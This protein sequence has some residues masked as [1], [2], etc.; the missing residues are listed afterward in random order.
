M[1]YFRSYRSISF[2][3]LILVLSFI[4]TQAQ[5]TTNVITETASSEA[6]YSKASPADKSPSK[7]LSTDT[8]AKILFKDSPETT[9][10]DSP[11]TVS[12]DFK[13]ITRNK[14]RRDR[15]GVGSEIGFWGGVS[16]I[17]KDLAGEPAGQRFGMFAIRYSVILKDNPRIKLKYLIDFVP[18][19]VINYRRERRF[20]TSP[21]T[22]TVTRDRQTVFGVGYNPFGFQ[23]NF[24]NRQ[25]F[26]PFIAGGGGLF[27]LAKATFEIH[28]RLEGETHDEHGNAKRAVHSFSGVLVQ[29]MLLDIVFSLDSVITAVGMA[30][31]LWVMVTA[32][33]VSVGVM[34]F[35]A[36]PISEFVQ[37]RPTIKVL[38]LSF[39]MLIGM[40]LVA[41]GLEQH[42]PK[43]YI[44]FAMA[45][46]LAVE[47]VNLRV[48]KTSTPPVELRGPESRI[49]H[50]EKKS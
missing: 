43:G 27:L 38:A 4:T 2:C 15:L 22:T 12:P 17:A 34:M 48:R 42:I 49:H 47:L 31:D 13:A 8:S 21:T 10:K 26:Q 6:S 37:E 11:E 39:L 36:K 24:R 7:V 41:E 40:A 20:R 50:E 45:F 28:E 5:D 14:T 44:Y 46:S 9:A 29:I 23:V 32:V 18:V 30:K 16:T 3:L 1:H 33:V 25:K 19:A 35:A